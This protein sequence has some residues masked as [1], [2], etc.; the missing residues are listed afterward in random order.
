[1][2]NI[3]KPSILESMNKYEDI[4][5]DNINMLINR[6]YYEITEGDN[7]V[8]IG[9]NNKIYFK[10]LIHFLYDSKNN[11]IND[12]NKEIEY[13][14][15]LKDTEVKLAKRTKFSDYARLYERYI[16]ILKRELFTPEKSCPPIKVPQS[17]IKLDEFGNQKGSGMFAY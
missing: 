4:N 1:M 15:R 6:I 3:K 9:N 12:F 8:D 13:E 2:D 10:D 14:E 16:N 7:I 11:K 5:L 17:I